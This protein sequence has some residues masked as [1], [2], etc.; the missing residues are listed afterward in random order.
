MY[1]KD[2]S[3]AADVQESPK[4][5]KAK[6]PRSVALFFMFFMAVFLYFSWDELFW[7][8][9]FIGIFLYHFLLLFTH[10][11][12]SI[13]SSRLIHSTHLFNWRL[14]T[15]ELNH[16]DVSRIQFTHENWSAKA[17]VIKTYK[18]RSLKL[19]RYNDKGLFHHL[20]DYCYEYRV[21]LKK[22]K[23]YLILEDMYDKQERNT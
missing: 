13:Q 15:R 2:V 6:E 20:E 21:P 3:E 23:G 19:Y 10:Y 17:V 12:F 11:T 22:S 7:R 8:Y 9:L 16:S 5:Y 14:R 4:I 1:N 18:G